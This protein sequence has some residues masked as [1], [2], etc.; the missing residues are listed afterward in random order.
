[1]SNTTL[2]QNAEMEMIID[3]FER[4]SKKTDREAV[5]AKAKLKLISQSKCSIIELI[6]MLQ[7][8]CEKALKYRMLTLEDYREIDDL[9]ISIRLNYEEAADKM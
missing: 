9:F 6:D 7:P 5:F 1:M 2:N 3:F 8:E 4:V